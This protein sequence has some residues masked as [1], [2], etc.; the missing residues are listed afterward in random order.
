MPPI[1]R[2]TAR[3]LP[4]SPAGTVLLLLDRDPARPEDWRWGTV[5]GAVDPGEEL[6]ATA[7]RELFEETGLVAAEGDLVGAFHVDERAFSYDGRD[8]LG[9]STFFALAVDA[10]ASV[11]F[12]HLMPAEIGHVAE[13]RWWAPD[14]LAA[15]GRLVAPDLPEIMSA[16]IA[17]VRGDT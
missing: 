4:V 16:A 6:R 1:E 14:G 3:V 17:A 2:A 12:A 5:G 11:T 15:D 9:H 13:A 8:Y 10:E 7:V